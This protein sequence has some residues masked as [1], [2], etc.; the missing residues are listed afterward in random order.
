MKKNYASL[1]ASN[2]VGVLNNQAKAI[3]SMPVDRYFIKK[4][5][6]VGAL[7]FLVQFSF[8]QTDPKEEKAGT[9]T[10][11]TPNKG[12]SQEEKDKSLFP[13]DFVSFKVRGKAKGTTSILITPSTWSSLQYIQP[14]S[15]IQIIF[16]KEKIEDPSKV[17]IKIYATLTNTK[18]DEKPL[19]VLGYVTVKKELE[20]KDNASAPTLFKYTITNNQV[21]GNKLQNTEIDV[22]SE[23][24][25]DGDQIKIRIENVH[26]DA[27]TGF[28]MIFEIDDYGFKSGPSSGF[29]WLKTEAHKQINFQASPWLGYSFHYRPRKSHL[30]IFHLIS[31]A[32][33]PEASV[34]Q[35]NN[36]SY[37][38]VG[39][40][41]SILAKTIK[42]S[43]GQLLGY[44][45]KG[46]YFTIGLNFVDS[47][48]TL[49]NL[50]K[51]K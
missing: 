34:L 9:P 3:P 8:G 16:D 15:Q 10:I 2:D 23:K 14:N 49:T 42:F 36:T 27:K 22:S 43:Y 38:G 4:M 48:Q 21:A 13:S 35:V 1:P 51:S 20:T 5:S 24:L 31:P 25:E 32:F 28:V 11:Q 39:G 40:Q 7:L 30:A 19:E 37:I 33:G 50:A 44:P 29:A 45:D 41:L 46:G 12:S 17:E 26:S 47:I 18:G 6:M